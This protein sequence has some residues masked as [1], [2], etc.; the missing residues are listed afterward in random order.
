MKLARKSSLRKS[1]LVCR[2]IGYYCSVGTSKT[3]IA[4]EIN[5]SGNSKALRFNCAR[6]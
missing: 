5:A 2:P 1:E 3:R 6:P 4:L